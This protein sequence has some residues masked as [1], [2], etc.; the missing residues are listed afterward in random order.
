[1]AN[2]RIKVEALNGEELDEDYVNGIE[3][4]GFAIL[5]D[6]KKRSI[7]CIHNLDRK[8]VV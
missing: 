8:S 3:C 2:Y 1:M 7:V 6:M 4:N 5:G